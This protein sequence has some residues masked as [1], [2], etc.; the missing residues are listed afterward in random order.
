MGGAGVG[1][2]RVRRLGRDAGVER[3]ALQAVRALADGLAAG[4]KALGA[5]AAAAVLAR[6]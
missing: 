6:V 3:V 4:V 1:V 2:A 5:G